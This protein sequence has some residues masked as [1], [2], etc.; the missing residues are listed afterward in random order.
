MNGS[1][2]SWY[3]RREIARRA[4]KRAI[5]EQNPH[6]LDSPIAA[7]VERGVIEMKDGLYHLKSD[8]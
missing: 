3:A 4:V 1:P 6:W 8:I 5:F 2:D 7:L